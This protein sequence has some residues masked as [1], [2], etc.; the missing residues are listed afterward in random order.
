MKNSIRVKKL[1][2]G[3][4]VS[5]R[6]NW[7][8]AGIRSGGLNIYYLEKSMHL[9]V[10]QLESV[11]LSKPSQTISSQYKGKYLLYDVEFGK[12]DVRQSE[13]F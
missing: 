1:W 13:L 5:L 9:N 10:N 8:K 6:D 7:I 2:Q 4:F 11:L 3:K 12:N